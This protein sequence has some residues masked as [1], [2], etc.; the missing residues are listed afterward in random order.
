MWVGSF[1][2]LAWTINTG[3]NKHNEKS[4]ARLNILFSLD[5]S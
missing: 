1:T 3:D 5:P 2:T 4:I